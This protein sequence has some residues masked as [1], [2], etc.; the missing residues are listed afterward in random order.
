MNLVVPAIVFGAVGTAGQR[1]TST[2]RIIA[3]SSII[4]ELASKLVSAYR[5][6]KIGDPLDTNTLMGPLIDQ[7]AV[8][9][10]TNAINKAKEQGGKVFTL[11]E[12][13]SKTIYQG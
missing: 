4:D 9:D 5:Q 2:R 6:V 8:D 7:M 1:C 12:N 13:C 11:M 3:H 10:Y